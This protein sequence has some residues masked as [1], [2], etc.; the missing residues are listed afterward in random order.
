MPFF[1]VVR[2]GKNG[3]PGVVIELFDVPEM[4]VCPRF[5]QFPKSLTVFS[6]FL[7]KSSFVNDSKSETISST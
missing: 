3:N 5:F 4:E 2:A 7:L 6:L 1:R